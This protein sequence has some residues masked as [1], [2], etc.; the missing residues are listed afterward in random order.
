[1]AIVKEMAKTMETRLQVEHLKSSM[2]MQMLLPSCLFFFA[3]PPIHQVTCKNNQSNTQCHICKLY[4]QTVA[5]PS[6]MMFSLFQEVSTLPIKVILNWPTRLLLLCNGY[7][8]RKRRTII[9]MQSCCRHQS[10]ILATRL[11]LPSLLLHRRRRHP[12]SKI[13]GTR[14][15]NIQRSNIIPRSFFEMSVTNA[16]KPPLDPLEV[17]RRVNFFPTSSLTSSS[18]SEMPKDWAVILTNAPLF[19]Q[20]A[21]ILDKLIAAGGNLGDGFGSD[22]SN[23]QQSHRKMSFVL[24]TDT[25]VRIINPKYYGDSR[26][27]MLAAIMDMKEKGVHF[28][29]GGRLEQGTE[30]RS[31]FVNGEEEVKSLPPNVQEMFTLLTEEE[32]RLDISSTELR[33]RLE[34]TQ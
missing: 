26:E 15:T 18:S 7:A 1:M 29:V 25:M 30:N 6:H 5:S 28:I 12:S 23:Q 8:K 32:F 34:H 11:S 33:K 20:K 3:A 9:A 17:E 14:W 21:S 13:F 31:T 2:E 10:V 22:D 24:G 4:S 16:D 27:N 19:S